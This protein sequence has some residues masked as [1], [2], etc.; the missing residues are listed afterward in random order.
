MKQTFKAR[1]KNFDEIKELSQF[2]VA[3]EFNITLTQSDT[4]FSIDAEKE[5]E[6]PEVYMCD[7]CKC[8]SIQDFYYCPNC[9]EK[10]NPEESES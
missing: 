9:G 5:E 7:H 8:I 2:L 6:E 3:L 1:L 4:Y 10:A